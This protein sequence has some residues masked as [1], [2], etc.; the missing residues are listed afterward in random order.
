MST[1]ALLGCYKRRLRALIPPANIQACSELLQKRECALIL[2]AEGRA[3]WLLGKDGRVR[4]R[5]WRSLAG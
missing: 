4:R 2:P 3:S 5:R 1:P